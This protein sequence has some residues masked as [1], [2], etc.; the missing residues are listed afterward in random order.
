[1]YYPSRMLCCALATASAALSGHASAQAAP[2]ADL[3]A[4][5]PPGEVIVTA[6]RRG[7]SLQS[8]PMAV[9]AFSQNTLTERSIA[10]PFDLNGAVPGLTVEADSGN[11]GLPSFAIRGRGQVYG[12]SA[13]SVETYFAEVPLSAPYQMPTLPPQFFDLESLQVAKGPQGTLFGRST[14]GGA[15][16]IVPQA[17]VDDF[18][19]YARVQGGTY[20]DFQ[21]EG[22]VN[23]PVVADKVLLRIAAFDWRRDGYMHTFAGQANDITGAPMGSQT[24]DNVDTTEGRVTLLVRPVASLTNT[25]LFTYHYDKTRSSAGSGL[26]T[27]PSGTAPQP[28]YRTYW[29]GTAVDLD[30][31]ANRVWA[32]INTTAYDIDPSLTLKNI[33]GYIDAAGYTNDGSDVDGV[34][35]N[36][37]DLP[38]VPDHPRRSRQITDELQLQGGKA[39]G[40]L[41]WILGGL[42]DETLEPGA[43]D[44]NITAESFAPRSFILGRMEQNDIHAW[45]LYGSGVYK[46]SNALNLS[47][48]Y[49]HSGFTIGYLDGCGTATAPAF[50]TTPNGGPAC[51][52][53]LPSGLAKLPTRTTGGDTYNIGLDYR[54]SAHQMIYGGY[55]RGY[56]HGGYNPLAPPSTPAFDA[57]TVDDFS[58]GLKD[59]FEVFNRPA[60]FNI[61]GYY[62]LYSNYQAAFLGV[63]G[64]IP[65]TTTTNIPRST[66]RGFEAELRFAPTS[67]LSVSASY[68]Y[69]DAFINQWRNTSISSLTGLPTTIDLSENPLPFVSPN[70]VTATFRLHRTLGDNRGE[71][72]LAPSVNYQ[73]RFFTV[74]FEDAAPASG[75]PFTNGESMRQAGGG[76]VPGYTTVDLRAEWNRV[77]GS[78]VDAAL[79]VTNLTNTLYFLGNSGTLNFGV[80]GNAYGPPRMASIELSTRF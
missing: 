68:A 34:A 77:L 41:S 20:G 46:L 36:L 75:V 44:L 58:L 50:S 9:A 76:V 71:L 25:T 70:K 29:T 52:A 8:V 11:A 17:P 21:L 28:G 69:I 14:T 65:I 12:S 1:M 2:A 47:A 61:E 10:A 22:A 48:G 3:S 24:Y 74:P 5:G 16:I 32:L 26:M 37:I 35:A 40:R 19:G 49:R 54:L 60:R 23:I 78:R 56:K 38:F 72:V 66:F 15:V 80:Q 64:G 43:E 7:E 51:A 27:T 45:G 67:W 59:D 57:E 39:G 79:N 55:R 33:F 73:D 31:P 53:T 18:G 42:L 30:K 62:D 63:V 6:R 13:G 4:R